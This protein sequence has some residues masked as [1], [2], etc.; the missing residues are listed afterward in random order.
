MFHLHHISI[1]VIVLKYYQKG[2]QPE[3]KDIPHG[4]DWNLSLTIFNTSISKS[5][6][7]KCGISISLYLN[8]Q[9]LS[10]I[11]YITHSKNTIYRWYPAKRA[12][13]AMLTH[14]RSD[15]F[16]YDTLDMVHAMSCLL[17]F[18]MDKF[19]PYL[20]GSHH[21]DSFGQ[22]FSDSNALAMELLQSCI[23]PRTCSVAIKSQIPGNPKWRI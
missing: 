10:S 15:P 17:C 2:M 1:Q 11:V 23:K 16:W 9:C 12:L 5:F 20:T 19:Y 18:V 22:K 8:R 3:W 14:G 6:Y 21:S 4:L 13:P 7:Q